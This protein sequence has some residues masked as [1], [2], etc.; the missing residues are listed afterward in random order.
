MHECRCSWRKPAADAANQRP[1]IYPCAPRFD[2]DGNR[3]GTETR[4]QIWAS[5]YDLN[6]RVRP[7]LAQAGHSNLH[8][9]RVAQILVIITSRFDDNALGHDCTEGSGKATSSS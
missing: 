1:Y 3:S 8:H 4:Q 9:G 6:L 2:V 5:G 7:Q